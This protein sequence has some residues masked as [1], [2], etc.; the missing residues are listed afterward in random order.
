MHAF[1]G[2]SAKPVVDETFGEV[3]ID[4]VTLN[5]LMVRTLMAQMALPSLKD[6]VVSID[7]S[8]C[9]E[10]QCSIDDLAFTPVTDHTCS[11]CSN[12]LTAPGRLRKTIANPLVGVLNRL[13]EGAPRRPQVHDLGLLPETL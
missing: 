6:R 11:Q 10:A 13:A 5:P 4:G 7:C 12:Q 2:N 8:A 9:G 1:G 3:S